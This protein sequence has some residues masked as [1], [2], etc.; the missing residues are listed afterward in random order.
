MKGYKYRNMVKMKDRKIRKGLKQ[1]L[2]MCPTRSTH[3]TNTNQNVY[4]VR[5]NL[6]V[7]FRLSSEQPLFLLSEV[8]NPQSEA[9]A[10]G[11]PCKVPP[12]RLRQAIVITANYLVDN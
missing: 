12:L 5:R 1:M 8:L 6:E 3:N 9:T 10:P 2:R 4:L 7:T 11:K